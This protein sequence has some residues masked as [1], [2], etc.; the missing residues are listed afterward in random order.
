MII[1]NAVKHR[2]RLHVYMAD[3]V[4]QTDG[5]E[6]VYRL[7]LAMY[8]RDVIVDLS[9]IQELT[10]HNIDTL[11]AIADLLR[12]A[13]HRLILQTVPDSLMTTLNSFGLSRALN[14]QDACE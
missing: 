10:A 2:S 11:V 14:L 9:C 3:D 4:H 12:T 8:D 5:L 7:A 1:E 13:G 6:A